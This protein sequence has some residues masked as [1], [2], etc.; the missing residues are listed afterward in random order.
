VADL[1]G[2]CVRARG[3]LPRRLAG[4]A[5]MTYDEFLAA[6]Q[7]FMGREVYVDVVAPEPH[8]LLL[9]IVH[10]ELIGCHSTEQRPDDLASERLFFTV[11]EADGTTG[12]YVGRHEFAD[13]YWERPQR[14]LVV[15]FVGG[16]SVELEVEL[17]GA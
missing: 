4:W 2:S 16:A 3:R 5:G 15:Q 17:E 9:A 1:G 8:G 11:G 10:G 13:A 7:Q 14:R 12:F 6:V